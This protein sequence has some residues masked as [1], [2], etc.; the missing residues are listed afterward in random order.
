MIVF[1]LALIASTVVFGKAVKVHEYQLENG[2]KILIRE[3][4]RAPVI[5]SQIWYKVGSS[6]EYDG[7]TGVSHVLEHMMFKGTSN[8]P[9]GEFS[10]IIAANGGRENAFTGR[11]YT[12]YYQHLEK[13]RLEIS[14][15]LESDR[16]R[17]LRLLEKEFDKELQVVME[18][19]RMRTDDKPR[20][21]TFEHF[22]AMV[23]SNGPYKNPVIG[24]PADLDNMKLN[25]LDSWYKRWY[26]PNNAILVVVGDVQPNNVVKLAKKYF[27]PLKPSAI[28]HQKTRNEIPQLGE[29][30][31]TIKVPAKTPYLLIGYKVPVLLG[32]EREWEAYALEVL[33]GILD[34]GASARLSKNL[35]RGSQIVVAA[36][37]G[38]DLYARLP[39]LFTL[40]ATPAQGESMEQVEQALNGEIKALQDKPASEAELD[41]VKA[42]VSA[43]AVYER[44]SFF[45]QAMQV[46][47]L[48]TV[49]LGWQKMDE[50][51]DRVNSVTARQVQFVARKYLTDVNRNVAYLEPLP[52]EN[53]KPVMPKF[54]DRHAH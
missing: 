49:G 54:G 1:L 40:S 22:M 16:M 26:A 51:V 10:R 12:A 34:A 14:L 7:I 32:I 30:R 45:Y 25:D 53:T 48:E 13:S 4:H 33:A 6:Y 47:L 42:Q 43:N 27:G 29:R 3:D 21:K 18:E 31:M 41:R 15:K 11:D 5:V 37:A 17:H 44:D 36:G 9:P 46:G 19:R 50:Y 35:I 8:Y 2:L 38:Y 52:L 28:N 23:Y 24:W 20:A 39:S